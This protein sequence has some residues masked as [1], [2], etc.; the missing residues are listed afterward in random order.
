MN[1]LFKQYIA[2]PLAIIVIK[3]LRKRYET[4]HNKN[5]GNQ[6]NQVI[7]NL[8]LIQ[9]ILYWF[10]VH[11]R[12]WGYFHPSPM[13]SVQDEYEFDRLFPEKTLKEFPIV[14]KYNPEA[15]TYYTNMIDKLSDWNGPI[16]SKEIPKQLRKWKNWN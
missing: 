13:W 5:V 16:Y 10:K 15:V 2:K 8:I 11:F 7:N 14:I 6:T 12:A 3:F 1:K 4:I 9:S